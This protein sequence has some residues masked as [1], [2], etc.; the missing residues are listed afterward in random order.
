MHEPNLNTTPNISQ[1]SLAAFTQ[2]PVAAAK[3]PSVRTLLRLRD[4]TS[5][6]SLLLEASGAAVSWTDCSSEEELGSRPPRL[7]DGK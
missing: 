5:M 2:I 3:F 4:E 7:T 6:P 1:L